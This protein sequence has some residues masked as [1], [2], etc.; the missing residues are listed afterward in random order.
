MDSHIARQLQVLTDPEQYKQSA[1]E[2]WSEVS[3]YPSY[4]RMIPTYQISRCPFTGLPH[5]EMLD[6][7]S[8][9]NWNI[10][11]AEGTSIRYATEEPIHSDHFVA[12]QAFLNLNGYKPR[13]NELAFGRDDTAALHSE[14]PE[15]PFITPSLLPDDIDSYAV[16]HALPIGKIKGEGFIPRYTLYVLTYYAADPDKLLKRRWD[17]WTQGRKMAIPMNFYAVPRTDY[18]ELAQQKPEMWDLAAWVRRGKL[19]WLD[20]ADPDLPLRTDIE[21]FPYGNIQG[22]R[23]GYRYEPQQAIEVVQSDHTMEQFHRTAHYFASD[24]D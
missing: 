19:R 7:Y 21:G 13:K 20:V 10:R 14:L 17:Q 16:I 9:Y 11:Y 18:W 6:T 15:V 1:T 23:H 8:L 3:I 5:T 12:V 2:Q 22:L 24:S 4:W